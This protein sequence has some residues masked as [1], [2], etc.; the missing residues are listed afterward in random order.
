MLR[1]AMLK[2]APFILRTN[3][4]SILRFNSTYAQDYPTLHNKIKSSISPASTNSEIIEALRGIKGLQSSYPIHDQLDETSQLSKDSLLIVSEVF[5]LAAPPTISNELLHDIFVLNLPTVVNL[6]VIELFYKHDPAGIITKETA[7][8]PLRHA[9]FNAEFMKAITLTDATVGHKNYID[10]MNAVL[11]R[12][13]IKLAVTAGGITLFTKFGVTAMVDAG[14]LSQSWEHLA[15]LNS[16]I[17]TYVLNSSFFV[18]IVRLG[19]TLVNSGG[20]YLTWQK[21]TFYNHWFKHA[22]ELLF[23]SKIVEADRAL[24]QGENSHEVVE[25][26]CRPPP[27]DERELARGLKVSFDRYGNKVRLLTLKDDLEKIKFQAYWMT[28]GDGFEWVEPDQDPADLEWKEHLE[29]YNKPALKQSEV[30]ALRW[31]DDLIQKSS[32]T[33]KL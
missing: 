32:D 19:R 10:A 12:G 9:L 14:I 22:D 25:E 21:G 5:K 11:K 20:D 23:S 4:F 8:I 7:L 26:L 6:K 27:N 16:I 15:A 29:L 13:L 33:E 3:Q 18:T 30:S 17:L 24:N 28:G 2:R 31:A 1:P